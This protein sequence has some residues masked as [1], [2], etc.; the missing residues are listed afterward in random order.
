MIE[1]GRGIFFPRKGACVKDTQF[2]TA[3]HFITCD[4]LKTKQ[5]K[6]TNKN[7][8]Q[9]GRVLV[10]MQFNKERKLVKRFFLRVNHRKF[11]EV[12]Y[13]VEF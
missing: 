8:D 10:K 3:L 7:L 4:L 13:N 9:I 2:S 1:D 11:Q 5:Y 6:T 12:I